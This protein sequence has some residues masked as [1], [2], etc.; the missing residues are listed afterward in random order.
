ML[1]FYLYLASI[2]LLQAGLLRSVRCSLGCAVEF[3]TRERPIVETPLGPTRHKNF[4]TKGF[5]PSAQ[6]RTQ[7][8]W[9]VIFNAIHQGRGEIGSQTPIGCWHQHGPKCFRVVARI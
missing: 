4:I 8:V 2:R 3:S 7:K 5:E 6:E 1:R 9:S